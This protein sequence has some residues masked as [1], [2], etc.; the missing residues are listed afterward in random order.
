MVV[1]IEHWPFSRT[2]LENNP[3]KKF[4]LSKEPEVEPEEI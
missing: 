1:V 3:D 4:A 2:Q